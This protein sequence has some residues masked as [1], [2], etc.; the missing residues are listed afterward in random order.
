M[1]PSAI[2]PPFLPIFVDNACNTLLAGDGGD[3]LFA[4]NERYA[5]QKIFE[6]YNNAPTFIHGLANLPYKLSSKI[7]NKTPFSKGYSFLTQAATPLPDRMENYNFL[8]QIAPETIFNSDL[9]ETIN[10]GKPLEYLSRYYNAPQEAST[11]NR[12]QFGLEKNLSRQ[13]FKKSQSYVQLSG[14]YREISFFR[15]WVSWLLLLYPKW[16]KAKRV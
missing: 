4:G 14:N 13:W 8:H 1:N 6:T 7:K 15:Q 12:M 3:E 16:H 5:K 9:L 2:H 10:T 11:L